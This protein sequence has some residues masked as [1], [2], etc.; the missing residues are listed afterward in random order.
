MKPE[1]PEGIYLKPCTT[2]DLEKRHLVSAQGT[3]PKITTANKRF[4]RFM[5][6]AKG[7]RAKLVAPG[8]CDHLGM[9]GP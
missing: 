4:T 5:R 3:L 6:S 9:Q 7:P 1:P 2:R 8:A